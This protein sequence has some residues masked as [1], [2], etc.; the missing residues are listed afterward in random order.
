[1]AGTTLHQSGRW[2][3]CGGWSCFVLASTRATPTSRSHRRAKVQTRTI[4]VS[5]GDKCDG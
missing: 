5:H 1:V 4:Y 2:R 3:S